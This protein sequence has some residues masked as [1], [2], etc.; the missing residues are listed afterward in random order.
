[1]NY[2]NDVVS[3]VNKTMKSLLTPSENKNKNNNKKTRKR[4]PT[5][6]GILNTNMLRRDVKEG[7]NTRISTPGFSRQQQFSKGTTII[8]KRPGDV[9][10]LIRRRNDNTGKTPRSTLPGEKNRRIRKR[11]HTSR[12]SK[13]TGGRNKTYRFKNII[14]LLKLENIKIHRFIKGLL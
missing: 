12:L 11:Q 9:N 14:D 1:M 10:R 7:R 3:G 2:L 8:T 6:P 13:Q 4:K 5:Q